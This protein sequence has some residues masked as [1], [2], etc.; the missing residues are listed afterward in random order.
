VSNAIDYTNWNII[1]SS[2]SIAKW[3]RRQILPILKQKRVNPTHTHSSV[4]IVEKII[5][6]TQISAYFGNNISIVTGITKSKMDFMKTEG[7]QFTQL[8]VVVKYDFK[9]NS[10]ILSKHSQKQ[11]SYQYYPWDLINL[12]YYLYLRTILNIYLI[13]PEFE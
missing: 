10:H 2:H 4:W 8:W 5:K 7:L 12:W 3:M 11:L 13:Y 1:V 9:R 6:L